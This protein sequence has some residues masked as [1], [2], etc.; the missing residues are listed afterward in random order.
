MGLQRIIIFEACR[1]FYTPAI[2][3]AVDSEVTTWMTSP[4]TLLPQSRQSPE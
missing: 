2:H 4:R 3:D 1:V